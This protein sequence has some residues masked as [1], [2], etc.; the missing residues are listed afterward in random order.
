MQTA[1]AE[2][3]GHS[4]KKTQATAAAYH[5]G[6]LREA[7]VSSGVAIVE[8]QGI[9][10][11]SLRNVARLA[12]VSHA[13]PYHHFANK[14]ALLAAIAERGYALLNEAIAAR[15][16]NG[17]VGSDFYGVGIAY[18]LFAQEHPALFRLMYASV[19]AAPV[20]EAEQLAGGPLNAVM[21]S[22][23]DRHL[24][25]GLEEARRIVLTMWSAV[26]GLA[27]L[28]LDGQLGWTGTDSGETL[29]RMVCDQLARL[30]ERRS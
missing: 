27:M 23:I 4:S 11:L 26:H 8:G 13:A 3:R 17:G 24:G 9:A 19:P 30:L 29:A 14:D 18:V 20:N 15:S 12:G 16:E 10:E 5:H 2:S 22:E 6:D 21:V 1:R 28:H 7:L 25:C